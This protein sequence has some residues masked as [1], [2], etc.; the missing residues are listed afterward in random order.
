MSE[1]LTN[2]FIPKVQKPDRTD[3]IVKKNSVHHNIKDANAGL[4][5]IQ[6]VFNQRNNDFS[7]TEKNYFTN[8]FEKAV[9]ED[10]Y[11][12]LQNDLSNLRFKE[13]IFDN[14]YMATTKNY[15]SY[16]QAM[17][18]NPVV[19]G[20]E[21]QINENVI[22]IHEKQQTLNNLINGQG[23]SDSNPAEKLNLLIFNEKTQL[24]LSE[25][26]IS[27][28]INSIKA[29]I[30][31]IKSGKIPISALQVNIT[32]SSSSTSVDV[33]SLIKTNSSTAGV[34]GEQQNSQ[35]ELIKKALARFQANNNLSISKKEIQDQAKNS[36]LPILESL[37]SKKEKEL[38]Q[39]R[40][41]I[42]EKDRHLEENDNIIS[43]SDKAENNDETCEITK[44]Q[45]EIEEL[46]QEI[47]DLMQKRLDIDPSIK[48]FDSITKFFDH[49]L[50][51]NGTSGSGINPEFERKKNVFAEVSSNYENKTLQVEERKGTLG[52]KSLL[53][54][55]AK[56]DLEITKKEVEEQKNIFE[57]QAS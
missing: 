8:L 26:A 40:D 54:N 52:V 24:Q 33:D 1:I 14:S 57:K 42:S 2:A 11:K 15:N 38:N 31:Q 17:Q 7:S 9:A 3:S 39:I 37:L 13:R 46:M 51:G 32:G 35:A 12:T 47:F 16:Q 10:A 22:K 18:S 29:Q 6:S 27:V 21:N 34:V 5:R 56:L 19:I 44:L 49:F 53:K 50:K 45:Q 36:I 48:I 28:D 55:E 23:A 25:V 43:S 41:Q 30:Q 20:I 4:E